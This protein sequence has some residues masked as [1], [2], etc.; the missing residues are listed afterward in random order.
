MRKKL[1]HFFWQW[2]GVWIKIPSVA[3]LVILLR[4][5]GVLQSWEWA[6]F[7]GYMRWRPQQPV[8]DRIAIVAIDEADLENLKSTEVSDRVYANLIKKLKTR[9]PRAIGLDIYRNLPVEPGYRELVAVFNSTPNLV[10]IEKVAGTKSWEIVPPP[11][12]L[13]AKKQVGANDLL[14]DADRKV[15]RGF[16]YI[17]DSEGNIVWSFAT[18]LALHYLKKEGISLRRIEKT[19]YQIGKAK[20]IPFE[21]ND[22]GYVNADDRGYQI[23]LKYPAGGKHFESVSLRDVLSNKLPPQWGKDRIIL[24]GKVGESYRDFFFTPYSSHLLGLAKP[25]TGVEIHA[26]L[27]SQLI[28]AAINGDTPIKSWPEIWEN[29]WILLWAGVGGILAW[30]LRYVGGVSK[31]SLVRITAP[32]LAAGVLLAST[33]VAFLWGWWIPVLPPLL[34]LAGS[35]IATIVYI[36]QTAAEIRK[37]FGRYL[38]DE[39]VANLLE[40]PSGLQLGGERKK[41]TIVTSDIRGFTA[42]SEELTPEEVVKILNIYLASMTDVITFYQGTIDKIMGDGILILFG[43]PTTRE[44]DAER[45]VACAIAM[46]LAMQSVNEK[47]ALLGYPPLEMGIGINTGEAVVGNIGSEKRAEY[48]VIGNQVNL[49][50]RIETYTVGGQILISE[51]TFKEVSYLVKIDSDLKIKP[52]GVKQALTVYEV[53]GIAGEYNLFLPK[54]EEVFFA[55]PKPIPI[56]YMPLEGK[57]IKDSLFYGKLVKL[58]AKGAEVCCNNLESCALPPTLSNIK[59]NLLSENLM[60]ISEDIYAKVLEKSTEPGSF[61]IRFTNKPLHIVTELNA[62][63]NSLA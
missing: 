44:N 14:E 21:A 16:L 22:G 31:V 8:D 23:L 7:D 4:L 32:F 50:F 45:A 41:I 39:V 15:R 52:K 53:S 56:Q 2:R 9:Q 38:T 60:E 61:Y 19:T 51:S 24:I 46:Q 59:L 17:S 35:A 54:V 27:V 47:I 62:L 10:G 26:N 29:L 48:S 42:L 43:A 36:A 11:P 34:S 57:Q 49:A 58:S 33:Y 28:N 55:L 18:H 12:E 63:Y 37:T 6:F 5:V 20:L 1:K 30:Q 13:K 40:S 3:G 25:M